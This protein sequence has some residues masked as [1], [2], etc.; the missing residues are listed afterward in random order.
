LSLVTCATIFAAGFVVMTPVGPVSTI[1]IR[2]A[3]IFGRRAGIVA[4]V[5][6]AVAV[7]T[8]ASIGVTGGA[9]VPRLFAPFATAWHIT[10][11]IVLVVVAALI[12]R[13]R[14]ALP[15]EGAQTRSSLAAGFGATLTIALANPADIVLFA[16]LFAGLG[17]VVQTP[18]ELALFA[19]VFF[20]GGCAYWIAL[21]LFLNRWR[22]GLTTVRIMWLNRTCSV[23]MLVAALASLVS[24]TR[25]AS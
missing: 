5:G 11:A 15:K 4:G 24:L 16:A 23:L 2:R 1:C 13:S 21:T 18:F 19:G 7:A 9:F 6:D 25:T 8:Y 10:V 22:S 20:A 12:W 14:P 17:I 3:L